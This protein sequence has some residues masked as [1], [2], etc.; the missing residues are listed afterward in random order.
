MSN[1]ELYIKIEAAIEANVSHLD[2]CRS[3]QK[4]VRRILFGN[5]PM[6]DCEDCLYGDLSLKYEPCNTCDD[7]NN[8][9]YDPSVV[10]C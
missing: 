7:F 8:Y 2:D 5:E 10:I 1:E 4:A 3:A 9:V 6:G